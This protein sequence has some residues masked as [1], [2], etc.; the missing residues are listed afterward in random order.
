MVVG[1]AGGGGNTP[2]N[3]PDGVVQ[4]R[5]LSAWADTGATI[6]DTAGSSTAPAAAAT[7][8][9]RK[10]CRRDTPG[11]AGTRSIFW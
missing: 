9:R 5:G 4:V 1:L 11:R 6:D 7:P 3:P 2:Q 8:T 10:S